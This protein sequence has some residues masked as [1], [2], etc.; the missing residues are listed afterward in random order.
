MGDF[1][2]MVDTML[3]K[4]KKKKRKKRQVKRAVFL[5]TGDVHEYI[6]KK[7]LNP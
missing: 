1:H 2:C 6:D 5:G 4:N 7:V 3:I